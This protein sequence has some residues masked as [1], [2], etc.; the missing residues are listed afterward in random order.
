M[1][2]IELLLNMHKQLIKN[3]IFNEK[4]IIKNKSRKKI[5]TNKQTVVQKWEQLFFEKIDYFKTKKKIG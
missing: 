3:E 4:L 1:Y 2:Q 5:L